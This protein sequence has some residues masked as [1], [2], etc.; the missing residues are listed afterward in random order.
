MIQSKKTKL[1]I[2]IDINS[3][4]EVLIPRESVIPLD[5]ECEI[6]VKDTPISLYEGNRFYVKDNNFI[7]NYENILNGRHLFKLVM[8]VENE[9]NVYIDEINID[10]I[11]CFEK[12]T[13]YNDELINNDIQLRQLKLTKDDYQEYIHSSLSS[14]EELVMNHEQKKYLTDKSKI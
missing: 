7:G 5:F 12:I 9:L 2:G 6:S 1:D 14:I 4:M 13:E 11:K 8:K 3:I 10:N